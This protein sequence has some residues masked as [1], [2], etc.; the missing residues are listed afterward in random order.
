MT[1]KIRQLED[2]YG[3]FYAPA[4][5]IMVDGMDLLKGLFL[6]IMS[7]QV[8]NTLKGMDRF[9]FTVNS[10]FNIKTREFVNLIS[11]FE[12][13]A[14]VQILL[15]Y[16]SK[17][18]LVQLHQ[19]IITSVQTNFPASGLPQVTVSGYDLSYCLSKGKQSDNWGPGKDS[20]AVVKVANKAGLNPLVVD[21]R[22]ER[23]KIE[24]SQES[25]FHFVEK[26]ATRNGYETFVF[27]KDLYFRPPPETLDEANAV[28]ELEWAS[29]LVSFSPE[30][31]ISEQVN[32]VEVR[33]WDVNNKREI[34]GRAGQGDESERGKSQRS[35]A[36]LIGKIC[37]DG[38]DLKVRA[39]V[40]SQE[41]ANRRAKALLKERAEKLVQ[42]S[43]ES[44]GIPD[45]VAGKIINL[46]ELGKVFSGAYYV[47]QSTHSLSS[48]GYKTTFKV[49]KSTV[50]ADINKKVKQGNP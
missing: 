45:I 32:K 38:G 24:Q 3:G 1:L 12:F 22:V 13:G 8:D 7:V 44:I 31:N 29:G 43:G 27:N 37:R 49:R 40:Y 36:E 35:G 11:L 47:E 20:D 48:S 34:V 39:P 26:L 2:K 16:K 42:G 46:K 14:S 23:P 19:G 41:E 33:G 9:T 25:L 4:C 17:E 6:E 30:I 50:P 5:Q 28:V 10:D 21:T 18:P 15:G